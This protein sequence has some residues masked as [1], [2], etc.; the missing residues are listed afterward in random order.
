MQVHRAADSVTLVVPTVGGVTVNFFRDYVGKST[1][2]I[3]KLR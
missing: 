1:T 2:L 3:S